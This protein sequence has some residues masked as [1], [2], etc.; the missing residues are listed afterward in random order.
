[1]WEIIRLHNCQW[2]S[3]VIV[4]WTA[5]FWAE[6]F[7][8]KEPRSGEDL[9]EV[10]NSMDFRGE[11]WCTLESWKVGDTCRHLRGGQIL[12]TTDGV[13]Y[14]KSLYSFLNFKGTTYDIFHSFENPLLLIKLGSFSGSFARREFK[15][16]FNLNTE[17]WQGDTNC[18]FCHTKMEIVDQPCLLNSPLQ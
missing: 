12:T 3:V 14:V 8:A 4:A 6:A 16:R 2:G 1:M 18:V 11:L 7:A 10:G 9:E 17:V 15:Q 5:W 13:Y